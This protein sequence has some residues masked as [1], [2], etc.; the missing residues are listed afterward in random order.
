MSAPGRKA[1]GD[2]RPVSG[3]SAPRGA[4]SGDESPDVPGFRTWRGVYWFVFAC[5]VLVVVVLALF[6]RAYA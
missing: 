3:I 5:F 1:D 6:S 4:P 2:N